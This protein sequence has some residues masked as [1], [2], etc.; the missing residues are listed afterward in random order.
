VPSSRRYGRPGCRLE[1]CF[2]GA[3]GVEFSFAVA[4]SV[5]DRYQREGV[6]KGSAVGEGSER[7]L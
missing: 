2:P 1:G 5:I 7:N 6:V 4:P 3:F